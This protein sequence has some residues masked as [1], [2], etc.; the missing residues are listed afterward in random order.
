MMMYPVKKLYV[1]EKEKLEK[2]GYA[3]FA[4]EFFETA[5]LHFMSELGQLFE[6]YY[7]HTNRKELMIS[8]VHGFRAVLSVGISLHCQEDINKPNIGEN[9]QA[10]NEQFFDVYEKALNLKYVLRDHHFYSMFSSYLVLGNMM[11]FNFDDIT[12]VY[13]NEK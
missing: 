9:K 5:L 8:Y 1:S 11:G 13:E 6:N 10:I 7:Y 2:E 12:Y 3:V 4:P